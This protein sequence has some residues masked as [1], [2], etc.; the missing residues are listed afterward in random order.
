MV[1]KQQCSEA[2][3]K[4]A[5]CRWK[6]HNDTKLRRQLIAGREARKK[7]AQAALRKEREK[8]KRRAAAN[9]PLPKIKKKK[10]GRRPPTIVYGMFDK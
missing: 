10:K 7:K 5:Q 3:R 9:K 4:L 2:G 1:S 6:K 8:D